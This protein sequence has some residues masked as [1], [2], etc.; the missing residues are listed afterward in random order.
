[1]K[2]LLPFIKYIGATL[3]KEQDVSVLIPLLRSMAMIND[4]RIIESKRGNA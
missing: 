1:M 2:T 3:E 4:K